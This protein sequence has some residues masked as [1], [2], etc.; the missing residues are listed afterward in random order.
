[1]L[2]HRNEGLLRSRLRTSVVYFVASLVC[3]L[4]GFVV[5]TRLTDLS[6]QYMVSLTTLGFGMILWWKNKAYLARWGPKSLQD[7]A[8]AH[9]LRGVDSRYHLFSFASGRLPDYLLAGPMG[10]VV[11]LPKAVA[12]A[13]A[14]HDGRWQ[15]DEGRPAFLRF[16]MVMSPQPSLGSPER[17]ARQ[18]IDDVKRFLTQRLEPELADRIPVEA[19]L[20]LTDPNVRLTVQGCT[21][22]ALFLRTLRSH[23]RR[24]PRVLSNAELDELVAALSSA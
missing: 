10:V 1:M 16:L 12:G 13:V 4:G 24:A 23:I 15:H 21:T 2:L 6:M 9:A 19:V 8:I 3:L 11:L 22:Q 5:S 7:P 14:C 20:T 17:E 18:S